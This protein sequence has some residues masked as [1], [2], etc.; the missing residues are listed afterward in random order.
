VFERSPTVKKNIQRWIPAVAVPTVIIAAAVAVPA[1]ANAAPTLPER[2]AQQVLELIA[3]SA[4]TPYSG[5]VEQTSALG[6]PDV[7]ALGSAGGPAGDDAA[8]G[9]LELATGSHTANVF[10][11]G[12]TTQRVQVLDRFAE[13]DLVR[14]GD[15]VWLYD[16]SAKEAVHATVTGAGETPTAN[17]TPADAAQRVIAAIEPSTGI[18]VVDTARVAG[19]AAYQLRLT[20]DDDATL[21]G[22]VVLSV[23]AETGLPLSASITATGES[24]PAFSVGFSDIDFSSPDPELFEFTPPSDVTVTEKTVDATATHAA[25]DAATPDAVPA[26][27]EPTVVGDGWDAVVVF[28][29]GSA[30]AASAPEDGTGA[31]TEGM[32][33]RLATRV[34]GGRVLGTSLVSVMLADDGRVLVGAVSPEHLETVAAQ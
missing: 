3:T 6:L 5:T 7:S 14:N 20:P 19:R 9:A 22:A 32:L 18:E 1:V 24:E 12:A 21:V 30:A 27:Q 33:D 23:D 4:S 25:L 31:D 2:S 10:V 13:R 17:I 11:G 15:S 16:S 26:G 8:A 28:P 29:A 34:D